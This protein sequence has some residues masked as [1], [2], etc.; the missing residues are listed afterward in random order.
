MGLNG[1]IFKK[2]N[3]NCYIIKKK[4]WEPFRI[5]LLNSTADPANFHQDWATSLTFNDKKA[6]EFKI[7]NK[8]TSFHI[9]ACGAYFNK[10]KGL[11]VYGQMSL[12]FAVRQPRELRPSFLA[13]VRFSL[14]SLR[15]PQ[16]Q[17][18]RASTP[19]I[20]LRIFLQ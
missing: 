11:N 20:S 5:G 9:F 16:K 17:P 4:N 6:T 1:F 13:L 18:H 10:N 7:S 15:P 14:V 19:Y 8:L 2:I 3:E 12:P